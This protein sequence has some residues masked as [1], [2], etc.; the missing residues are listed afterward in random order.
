MAKGPV[1]VEKHALTP[2]R[3]GQLTD[4]PLNLELVAD[5]MCCNFGWAGW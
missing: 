5:R 4:V 3:Y 1:A 2:A